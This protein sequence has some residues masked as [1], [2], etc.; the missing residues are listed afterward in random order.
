VQ[1]VGLRRID[2]FPVL[3]A[4]LAAKVLL[5]SAKKKKKNCEEI[6]DA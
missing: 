6:K 5:D 4:L 2:I 3:T 1:L